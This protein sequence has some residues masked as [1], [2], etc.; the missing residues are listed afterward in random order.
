MAKSR[1]INITD[2][3]N[4]YF[5]PSANGVRVRDFARELPGAIM[6]QA[7]GIGRS[8]A[9]API[10]V[11]ASLAEIPNDYMGKQPFQPFDV[12]GLGKT[13]TYARESVDTQNQMGGGP[14]ATATGILSAGSKAIGDVAFL[15]GTAQKLAGE[16]PTSLFKGSGQDLFV[17]T[18]ASAG[19]GKPTMTVG[20]KT[21]TLDQMHSADGTKFFQSL[22]PADQEKFSAFDKIQSQIQML[23]NSP[24]D[25]P[26]YRGESGAPQVGGSHFTTD[27]E[28]AKS[29]ARGGKPLVEKML[30]PNA[31]IKVI[32]GQDMQQ[33]AEKGFTHESQWWDDLFKQ[34][35]DAVVG[36]DAMN[37][38]KLD[39]VVKPVLSGAAS[40]AQSL[41]SAIAPLVD[42]IP[43]Q[44]VGNPSRPYLNDGESLF[45]V[46]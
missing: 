42:R 35:Y 1:F 30:P 36:T 5:E 45:V 17:N 23:Q 40:K 39:V 4:Q 29:F 33:A 12:P 32:T 9:L 7:K 43:Q 11:G 22:S 31:R 25:I 26:L 16:V 24:G 20:G 44:T 41:Q 15:G 38:T 3:I 10:R 14:L 37:G 46:P 6:N 28:W 18:P 2:T 8:L 13:S 19:A 27:P 21:L 34:G